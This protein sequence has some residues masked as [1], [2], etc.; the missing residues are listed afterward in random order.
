MRISSLYVCVK[1]MARG[2]DFYEHFFDRKADI[3]DQIYS[4]FII[5]GFRFGLFAYQ[6]MSEDHVY[7]S[8]CL[9]SVEIED[10]S[11]VMDVLEVYDCPIVFPLTKIG[12]NMVFE[13]KDPE[14]NHI[15]VTYPISLEK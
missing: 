7:G 12:P 14:G 2:I 13:F 1:D 3:K 6:E 15:E 9:P 11:R 4:V 8:N 10:V 5:N